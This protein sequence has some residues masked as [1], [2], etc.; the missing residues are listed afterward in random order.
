MF[1]RIVTA[2]IAIALLGGIFGLLYWLTAGFTGS[3]KGFGVTVDGK[4]YVNDAADIVLDEGSTV[5]VTSP[6][7]GSYDVAVICR[8]ADIDIPVYIGHEVWHWSD[9]AG[10][11]LTYGFFQE[12]AE[13]N[14]Y[15]LASS[16]LSAIVAAAVGLSEERISFPELPYKDICGDIFELR[17][18]SG[19]S[20][21]SIDF[22]LRS[23]VRDTSVE[24]IE[25]DTDGIIF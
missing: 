18:S 11:D 7:F 14:T 17:I 21:I 2:I 4:L 25:T 15:T 9:I 19:S 16:D 10:T 20:V 6:L 23:L 1:I 5:S 3:V 24:G 12:G 13:D 8:E 22:T